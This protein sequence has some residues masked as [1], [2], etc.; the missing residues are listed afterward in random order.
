[1]IME[2]LN[3]HFIYWSYQRFCQQV[4][5]IRRVT[6]A[7]RSS[8]SIPLPSSLQSRPSS[9]VQP[10][11]KLWSLQLVWILFLLWVAEEDDN[12]MYEY[13]TVEEEDVETLHRGEWMDE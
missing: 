5:L 7:Q 12:K 4:E 9:P 11:L 2:L 13:A 1:M 6:S 8:N 10:S 3:I